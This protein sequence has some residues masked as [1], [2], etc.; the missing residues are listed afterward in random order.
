VIKS[1]QYVKGV[2]EIVERVSKQRPD[3]GRYIN[4]HAVDN[5]EFVIHVRNGTLKMPKDAAGNQEIYPINVSEE[6]IEEIASTFE[7]SPRQSPPG[8]KLSFSNLM[9]K[10]FPGR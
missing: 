10:F 4:H 9:S 6:W 7:Q 5:S 3:I 8:Q 1:T 2:R